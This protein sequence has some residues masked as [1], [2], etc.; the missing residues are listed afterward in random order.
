MIT[1]LK[2]KWNA[3]Q[4]DNSKK[5]RVE[6]EEFHQKFGKDKLDGLN[7]ENYTNLI[8]N[9]ENNYFTY[10]LERK[11]Y[12]FGA[13]GIGSSFAYGVYKI[14]EPA[15]DQPP[16][17]TR[18]SRKT[19]GISV[20][21]AEVFFEK[22]VK[23]VIKALSIKGDV[24]P[25][26]VL[27]L[28]FMRKIA[29][30]YNPGTLL[31]IYKNEVIAAIADFFN[32]DDYDLESVY[33]T[34]AILETIAKDLELGS[35]IKVGQTA[36]L[37]KFLWDYF[38][39]TDLFDGKNIIYY[40]APGTGKTYGVQ[41]TIEQK[42]ILE[43]AKAKFIQF[44]PS[45]SYEDFI[46]GLKPQINTEGNGIKLKLTDGVFKKFCREAM[47][48]LKMAREKVREPINYYFIID[49]INRANLST[50]FGELLLCIEENKRIDFDKDGNIKDGGMTLETQYSYLYESNDDA[51]LIVND[52]R[53]FGV[54][55]N[56]YLI[57]T[58]NDIDKSIDSFD[59]ALRRRF[60]WE[61]KDFD[62]DALASSKDLRDSGYFD[63]Y[64][65]ICKNLNKYIS[66]EL[67][68]GKSYEIGHAYF[69]DIKL[70]KGEKS[71]EVKKFTSSVLNLFNKKLKPL[72]AE[73]LR[74][75]YSEQDIEKK[76]K[77]AQ[78]K[79]TLKTPK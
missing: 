31:P 8:E 20:E 58:M 18:E 63:A 30:M 27:S 66:E 41:N 51:V 39:K 45:Y 24:P 77:V 53:K 10:L 57:G 2:D 72:I 60:L 13:Y 75:E 68:L 40:G 1:K 3:Y 23:K 49:E 48:E 78:E 26:P 15:D 29:Y 76:L 65:E 16:Y 35:K 21:K 34:E 28:N 42:V 79:F 50:V 64:L 47:N 59:L 12:E 25:E 54:P 46:E 4:N 7:L 71:I 73:Y 69:M 14:K 32:F 9:K 62:E 44:H 36:K 61:R 19:G 5:A 22:N 43:G 52:E 11:T 70:P 6:F 74:G 33:A 55:S 56:L 38:G 67:A 17:A 37:G